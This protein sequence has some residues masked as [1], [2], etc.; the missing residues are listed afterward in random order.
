MK[1]DLKQIRENL[2]LTQ[3]ELAKLSNL[4]RYTINK[5]EN[6]TEVINSDTIKSLVLATGVPANKIFFDFDVV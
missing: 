4:S 1:N 3:A 6:G 2:G 5:I